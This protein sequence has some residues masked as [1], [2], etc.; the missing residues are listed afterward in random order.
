LGM[1]KVCMKVAQKTINGDGNLVFRKD[2]HDTA[3]Y[4]MEIS[5]TTPPKSVEDKIKS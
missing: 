1:K 4:A 5:K 2:Q 3:V